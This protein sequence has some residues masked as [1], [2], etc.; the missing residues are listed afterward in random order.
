MNDKI[1]V[2]VNGLG[3]PGKMSRIIAQ[4]ILTQHSGE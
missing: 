1:N 3:N 2:M 4:G